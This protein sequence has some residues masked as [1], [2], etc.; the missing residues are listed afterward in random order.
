MSTAVVY[1]A[2]QAD[3]LDATRSFVRSYRA[4]DAGMPH[5]LVVILKGFDDGG[6][7]AGAVEAFGAI[8]GRFVDAE[9][10]GFDLGPYF[11]AARSL[12]HAAYLFLNT[13]S[14]ILAEGWLA[15]FAAAL[16]APGVGLAGATASYES[17]WTAFEAANRRWKVWGRT[18]RERAF[19]RRNF[20]PFPNPHIRT[21]AFMLARDTLGRLDLPPVREKHDAYALESGKSGLTRQV[22][23]LGLDA[24]VVDR[25]GK[26]WTQDEWP[27]SRTFRS[28]DEDNLLVA[29][30]QTDVFLNAD[31][32]RRAVLSRLAWGA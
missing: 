8:G 4:F 24:V 17:H 2:R 1:L 5:E 30:N 22:R 16:A 32:G 15:K 31:A 21:N 27:A 23:R 29:D 20:D 13:F 14:R 12:D 28:G 11:T 18:A 3:G 10:R 26:R 19:Y 6:A 7:R 9:D 25:T